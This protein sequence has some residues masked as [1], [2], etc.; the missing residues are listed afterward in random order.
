[1]QQL[2]NR[3]TREARAGELIT[4]EVQREQI[5]HLAQTVKTEIHNPPLTPQVRPVDEIRCLRR[6]HARKHKTA[7]YRNAG[8]QSF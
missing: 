7:R 1:M 8:T 2:R 4:L 5:K 3:Y 6:A